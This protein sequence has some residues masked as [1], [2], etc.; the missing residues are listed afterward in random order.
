M[1]IGEIQTKSV[2]EVLLEFLPGHGLGGVRRLEVLDLSQQ[3]ARGWNTDIRR[4]TSQ[5]KENLLKILQSYMYLYIMYIVNQEKEMEKEKQ[6]CTRNNST[7]DIS[8]YYWYLIKIQHF[9]SGGT[10][11]RYAIFSLINSKVF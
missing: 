10:I 4:S 9:S 6:Y 3:G 7:Y 5:F 1:S 2:W 8:K 11:S